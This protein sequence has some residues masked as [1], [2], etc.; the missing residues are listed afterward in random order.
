MI[1]LR[2]PMDSS[3]PEAKRFPLNHVR[4]IS[5]A[6]LFVTQFPER[7]CSYDFVKGCEAKNFFRD[8]KLATIGEGSNE[9]QRMAIT[10]QQLD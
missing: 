2:P 5:A 9:I 8:A 6:G 4:N 10:R 3:P 1:K 7:Y